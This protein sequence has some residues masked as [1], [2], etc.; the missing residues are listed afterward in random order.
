MQISPEIAQSK[1][2]L[3]F[4]KEIRGDVLGIS[5]NNP[6]GLAVDFQGNIYLSDAGNDRIIKF[7]D[8]LKPLSQFGGYGAYEGGL[9]YPTF[10]TFDNGLNMLVSDEKN[11]RVSRFNSQ[12]NYVDQI[13][14]IDPDDP[15]RFG[16]PS[17]IGCTEYGEIWVADREDNQILVFN[18]VGN[19]DH[20]LGDYGYAGGQLS[21]PEKI[22]R[23]KNSDFIVCDA[24]NKR[25]I[26]YDEYGNYKFELSSNE[27][28]YPISA[29]VTK[30]HYF[31]LDSPL[32]EVIQMN[33]KKEIVAIFGPKLPGDKQLLTNPS[34]ILFLP[35]NKVLISDSG[36]NR[37]VLARLIEEE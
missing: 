1:N 31:V 13:S 28:E 9:N 30:D 16:Y 37:L 22:I 20:I 6:F 3:I 19:F 17:G 14:L 23:D 15:N 2:F 5:L 21:S 34:D 25:M 33:K 8:S 24:G 36:N 11:R 4:E 10:I 26:I 35:N 32:G 29:A 18:N 12:L 27:F 7:N